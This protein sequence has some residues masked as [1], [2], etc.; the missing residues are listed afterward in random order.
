MS[1]RSFVLL[2]KDILFYAARALLDDIYAGVIIDYWEKYG[3]VFIDLRT[4]WNMPDISIWT[5][6]L[7]VEL[8]MVRKQKGT[9]TEMMKVK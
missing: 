7:V 8:E 2:V 9:H 4:R 5:E 6:K 3:P 1:A